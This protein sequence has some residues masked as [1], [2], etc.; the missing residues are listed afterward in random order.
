LTFKLVRATKQ[1]KSCEF[2][3]NPFSGSGDISYTNKK[4][5]VT[6]PKRVTFRSS[7]PS[8]DVVKNHWLHRRHT[9]TIQLY[10]PGGA[11]TQSASTPCPCCILLSRFE[12]VDRWAYPEL[13]TSP[14][15]GIWTPSR[16][17][18]PT[19]VHFRNGSPFCGA[20][21][22]DRQTTLLHLQ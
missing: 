18:G 1:T 2:G 13:A 4:H 12:Y 22:N 8:C 10:S 3:T 20:H 15:V 17:L 6:A 16:F 11:S 5:R 9:L 19:R 21:N 14:H 7:L